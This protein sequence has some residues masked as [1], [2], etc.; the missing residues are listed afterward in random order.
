NDYSCF[1]TYHL[2]H[3]A[4]KAITVAL[5]G[6]G[7]DELFA[8]YGRYQ[9]LVRRAEMS[10]VLPPGLA[11]V[12][13]VAGHAL[14]PAGNHWRRTFAQYGLSSSEMLAD[15]LCI[16]FRLDL[17]RRVARGPLAA[18]L[19]H[20]TPWMLVEQLLEAA[21]PAEVGLVNA[22]RHLDMALTLAGGIL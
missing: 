8:G 1:P 10:G 5:S 17:L 7:A 16:G 13:A 14:L 9:R 22:M 4:R 18:A 12:A 21:P 20:Y 2:C 11:R 19:D 6:D 3:E 15:M